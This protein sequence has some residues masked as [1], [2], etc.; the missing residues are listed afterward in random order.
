[1]RLVK[2]SGDFKIK[3]VNIYNRDIRIKLPIILANQ[4]QRHFQKGFRKGG[5]QTDNSKGGWKPRKNDKGRA[6][7]VKSGILRRDINKISQRFDKIEIGTS[8]RTRDY[9]MIQ[10]EG[11]V[12]HPTVTQKM[13]GYAWVQYKKTK[14]SK[15]K[16][17]ALT[18]KSR[19]TV[20]I[21][22]R[23]FIGNSKDLESLNK[24]HIDNALKEMLI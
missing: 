10:N 12:T 21:P 1:M 3:D 13:R 18:K 5:G 8:N 16:A 7:L 6:I 17:I 20:N 14:E 19:L 23:E 2:I 9:A 4:V 15:W 22:Q 24:L 11:G